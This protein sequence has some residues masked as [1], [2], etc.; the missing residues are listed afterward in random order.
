MKRNLKREDY[1]YW[2]R[3][4]YNSD[5]SEKQIEFYITGDS[6]NIEYELRIE[7]FTSSL[8]KYV[9]VFDTLEEAKMYAEWYLVA[10]ESSLQ[11]I[12]RLMQWY[13]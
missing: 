1:K 13:W 10:L 12:N 9:D 6:Y 11:A 2:V 5:Y 4:R 3:A 7:D 8:G